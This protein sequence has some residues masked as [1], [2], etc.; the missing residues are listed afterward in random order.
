MKIRVKDLMEITTSTSYDL[1]YVVD[2]K[3]D[4]V[5]V[6][7]TDSND[8]MKELVLRTE[9][10]WHFWVSKKDVFITI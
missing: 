2:T 1:I 4:T 5:C 3:H 10:I 9:Y 8:D 7:D 6:Y